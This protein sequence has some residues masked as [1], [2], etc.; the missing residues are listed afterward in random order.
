MRCGR[1]PATGREIPH[2]GSRPETVERH[3]LSAPVPVGSISGRRG[4]SRGNHRTFP[5]AA[6]REKVKSFVAYL[7]SKTL[8][9]LQEIYTSLF[10]LDPKACLYLTYHRWG[11]HPNRTDDLLRLHRLYLEAG[12]QNDSG[13]LPDYLPLVLEFLSVCGSAPGR[14]VLAL[15][16]SEIE[17]LS[18]HLCEVDAPYAGLCEIL[19]D[20]IDGMLPGDTR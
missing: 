2:E 1:R 18:R 16:Q 19:T 3:F 8:L 6:G 11:Q 13:E 5:P 17:A 12:Y 4:R 7:G 9:D 10:D 14:Q 20:L 15:C